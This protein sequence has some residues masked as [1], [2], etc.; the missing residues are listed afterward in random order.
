MTKV[1][2]IFDETSQRDPYVCE[3]PCIPRKGEKIALPTPGGGAEMKYY[4]V[5]T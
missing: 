4:E 2:V 5:I 3:F 1:K